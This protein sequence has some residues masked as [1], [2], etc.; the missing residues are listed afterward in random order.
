MWKGRPNSM[1]G[2]DFAA[3][4]AYIKAKAISLKKNRV[5]R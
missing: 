1:E 4:I 2:A 3:V 5:F